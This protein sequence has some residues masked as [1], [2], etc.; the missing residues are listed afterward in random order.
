MN[1]SS[2]KYYPIYFVCTLVLGASGATAAT[3][4]KAALQVSSVI[5]DRDQVGGQEETTGPCERRPFP[6]LSQPGL[7]VAAGEGIVS[8]S[9]TMACDTIYFEAIRGGMIESPDPDAP[10]YALDIR[11]MD[12]NHIPFFV[13]TAGPTPM[14]RSWYADKEKSESLP[15]DIGG[16][17][18]AFAILP[19]AARALRAYQKHTDHPAEATDRRRC[20]SPGPDWEIERVVAMMESLTIGDMQD[21]EGAC[22][23]AVRAPQA[24]AVATYTHKVTIKKKSANFPLAQEWEHSAVLLQIYQAGGALLTDY[25]TCNHGAC[26]IDPSMSTQCTTSVTKANINYYMWDL[27]CDYYG[28]PYLLHLCNSD[29]LQEYLSVVNS[30]SQ[31]WGI[32]FTP[33]VYAPSCQ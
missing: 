3:S 2:I 18:R 23:A 17:Q 26:A 31:D 30:S 5:G 13:Q 27:M 11:I 24:N 29:T 1:R 4:G 9:F 16:R 14:A 15:L 7:E 25:Y 28:S 32:C 19:S 33:R 8:G 10:L 20:V 22:P 21:I 6:R 12:Q